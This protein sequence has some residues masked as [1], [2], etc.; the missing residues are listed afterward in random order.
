[1]RNNSPECLLRKSS[2]LN[3]GKELTVIWNLLNDTYEIW[4]PVYYPPCIH[5]RKDLFETI[6]FDKYQIVIL[7]SHY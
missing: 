4:G 3:D 7:F 5:K 6:V 1:M 2:S